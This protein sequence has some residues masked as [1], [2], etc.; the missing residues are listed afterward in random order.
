MPTSKRQRLTAAVLSLGL[1]GSSPAAIAAENVVFVT[2]AFRRSIAV[3]DLEYLAETGKARG[4][5]AD[6]LV[7]AKQ[8]PEEVGKLLKAELSIPL[9]LTSRLLS[10]RL[11]EALLARIAQIIY[12]L[13][14][15]RSGIP[16]LR[17]G[18]INAL[19]ATDG[20]LSAISFLKAYPVD[21][22]EV[23]I[24]ALLAV[25][26]KAKSVSELIQFF[27]ESPLDGLRGN[28]AA[29]GGSSAPQKPA[30]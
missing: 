21:E 3:T 18:V 15:K 7:I 13:Y 10:T 17:A 30:P 1:I 25:L 8:K 5:M 23:S 4:L 2:G 16:A 26:Q 27:M 24:P 12:P 11:G 20:K 28:S 29:S 9:L 22:M 6:V 14:A 19:V